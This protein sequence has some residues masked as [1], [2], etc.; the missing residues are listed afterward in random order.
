MIQTNNGPKRLKDVQWDEISWKEIEKTVSLLQQ[1]IYKAS[2]NDDKSS[3]K[4]LQSVLVKLQEAKLIAVKKVTTENTGRK[5]G[6]VDRQ[7]ITTNAEKIKLAVKLYIDGKAQLIRRVWIPKPGKSSM[8]P[9][10]IPTIQDRAKQMLIKMALE[11]AWEAIFE[12]NSF[13]F[14]P[15]RNCH[16]AIG[17][18]FN[19]VRS[20]TRPKWILD[21]DLKGCYDNINHEYLL[22]CLQSSPIYIKNQ[23]KSWLQAGIF[24]GYSPYNEDFENIPVNSKGTPQGGVISPLL[25]NIALHGMEKHLKEWNS[26]LL[27]PDGTYKRPGEK[28]MSIGIIRYADDF[29][30]IHYDKQRI[31][32]AK[33]EL[34]KWLFKTSKLELSS[35]K[36]NI[37]FI[38]EG[39]DF[40]GFRII[41]ININGKYR[42]KIYPQKSAVNR[43]IRKAHDIIFSN[44]AAKS[45]WLIVKLRPILLGWA[46]YYKYSECSNTFHNLDFIIWKMLKKWVNRRATAGGRK[47]AWNN[48]FPGTP[49]T[50]QG[51][52]YLDKY[53]FKASSN[54]YEKVFLPKTSWVQ[55]QRW[56]KIIAD[57]SPYDWNKE[58]WT[59][60]KT[61]YGGLTTSQSKLLLKQ[62]FLCPEC[63]G[64]INPWSHI[65]I[66][67]KIRSSRKG[68]TTS[69]NRQVLHKVC[70]V[71][72]TNDERHKLDVEI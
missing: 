64:E 6:G 15:G 45:E 72:K 26:K 57:F 21:A 58:Y 40:L 31:I 2:R 66:D 30:I 55:S 39:F 18:I 25:A 71:R 32:E 24:E 12:P 49:T 37:K 17:A 51:R 3:V 68:S 29:V 48:Y 16:D 47:K 56:T 60:R 67:H 69:K 34:E 22:S 23:I 62:N 52:N 59:K 10:G 61:S 8:R 53:V 1:R 65:E 33:Q 7:V 19:N 28:Y 9:V 38:K 41:L 11:P 70:H 5:T 36:T 14:R 20:T 42:T 35:E 27:E 4:H 46:N 54:K 13:G 50:F 63:G 43:I 44:K